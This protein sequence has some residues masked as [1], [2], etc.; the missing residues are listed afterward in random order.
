MNEVTFAAPSLETRG[1]MNV[2][3]TGRVILYGYLNHFLCFCEAIPRYLERLPSAITPL[4]APSH[5]ILILHCSFEF[6]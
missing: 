5:G 4:T 3:S 6:L 1:I 2:L